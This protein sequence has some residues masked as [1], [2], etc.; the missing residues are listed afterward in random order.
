MSTGLANPRSSC[1]DHL[2]F[3]FVNG[4]FEVNCSTEVGDQGVD[5]RDA[6]AII[7]DFQRL[8]VESFDKS[9][10][11]RPLSG[12]GAESENPLVPD[13]VQTRDARRIDLILLGTLDGG[14]LVSP[15]K[16]QKPC[17]LCLIFQ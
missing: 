10:R 12:T 9:P 11:L 7:F 17:R 5:L 2:A 1:R 8:P 15:T 6:P 14:R 4:A 13:L 3:E 16:E